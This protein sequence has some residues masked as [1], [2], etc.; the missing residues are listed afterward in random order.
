MPKSF[1]PFFLGWMDGVLVGTIY[2]FRSCQGDGR[3]RGFD[4]EMSKACFCSW[5]L[6]FFFVL[7]W[8]CLRLRTLICLFHGYGGRGEANCRTN[9]LFLTRTQLEAKLRRGKT[10]E[11]ERQ[12]SGFSDH[13]LHCHPPI[14]SSSFSSSPGP[15]LLLILSQPF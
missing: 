9:L 1:L 10:R 3:R 8:P 14:L 12:G 13:L 7:I 5:F 15:P 4:V 2:Y 6:V 11:R